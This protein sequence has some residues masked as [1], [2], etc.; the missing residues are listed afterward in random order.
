MRIVTLSFVILLAFVANRAFAQTDMPETGRPVLNYTLSVSAENMFARVHVNGSI[1]LLHGRFAPMSVRHNINE[2]LQP[3][4]N[5]ITIDYEPFDEVRRAYTPHEG[6]AIEVN[7]NRQSFYGDEPVVNESITLYSGRYSPE[8]SVMK[9]QDASVFGFGPAD[10]GTGAFAR[11]DFELVPME[12]A[13]G[14]RVSDGHGQRLTMFFEVTDTPMPT[15]VFVEGARLEDTPELRQ[16][17]VDAYSNLHDAVAAEDE[18]RFRE[19]T[20]LYNDHQAQVLGYT[21]GEAL[22]EDVR[23]QVPLGA[24]DGSSLA[25]IPPDLAGRRLEFGSEGRTV[26]FDPDPI[27]FL[28]DSGT[29]VAS[30]TYFFCRIDG[31]LEVCHQQ[32]LPY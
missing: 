1:Q 17:L 10:H 20:R 32:S 27:A 5:T 4:L 21:S 29:Q 18:A 12:I 2:F 11:Q 7:L 30:Y 9:E 8:E 14:N 23:R 13:Y 16:D 6:V 19:I 25:E 26:R 15:P 28:D 22:M 31:Q 3:G 24:P